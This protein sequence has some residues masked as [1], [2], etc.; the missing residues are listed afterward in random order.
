MGL[1]IVISFV[2]LLIVS[3]SVVLVY[4]TRINVKNVKDEQQN[5]EK[6]IESRSSESNKH[7][8]FVG[9]KL[10]MEISKMNDE[11]KN[12]Q[13]RDK[14]LAHEAL[15]TM[16]NQVTKSLND[17]N[18]HLED[19]IQN[20]KDDV[21]KKSVKRQIDHDG[22]RRKIEE[23]I[24]SLDKNIAGELGVLNKTVI[25]HINNFDKTFGDLSKLSS[26]ADTEQIESMN[27]MTSLNTNRFNH[28]S[29]SL[30]NFFNINLLN[31]VGEAGVGGV[32]GG[33]AGGAVGG[34]VGGAANFETWFD[35]QYFPTGQFDGMHNMVGKMDTH[36]TDYA[37]LSNDIM[38][39]QEIQDTSNLNLTTKVMANDTEFR[40]NISANSRNITQLESYYTS[41]S[42]MLTDIGITDVE[43]GGQITLQDLNDSIQTNTDNM[44]EYRADFD[45]RVGAYITETEFDADN[46]NISIDGSSM[47]LKE[48]YNTLQTSIGNVSSS[49]VSDTSDQNDH[50]L[51]QIGEMSEKVGIIETNLIDKLTETEIRK[52]TDTKV[53]IGQDINLINNGRVCFG[54]KCIQMNNE[55]DISICNKNGIANCHRI[56]DHGEAPPV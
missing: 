17:Q 52:L 6:K 54:D 5:I 55:N 23:D 48:M 43:T 12:R 53:S 26:D 15:E 45:T 21:S 20:T 27:T 38:D 8:N 40:T 2:V 46:F 34:A 14:R 25:D 28:I 47:S 7:T 13:N 31:T 19:M 4:S 41:L 50:V 44:R 51:A 56:W 36:L 32:A 37:N 11:I 1:V 33:A 16:R 3:L 30:N 9:N 39:Q 49:I 18:K 24:L 42:K 22:K 29:G 10:N 35:G